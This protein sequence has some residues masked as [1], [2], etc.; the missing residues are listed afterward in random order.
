V[1]QVT[2]P[3]SPEQAATPAAPAFTAGPGEQGTACYFS[4]RAD[5][6]LTAGGDR[7]DSKALVAGHGRLPLG[8]RAR[9]TNL[10]NG[11]SVEVRIVDRF[12]GTSGRVINLSEQA[13]REIGML[14]AGTAQVRVEPVE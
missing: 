8:S 7:L 6:A 9:V 10:G 13:A 4:S 5:G 14:R 12:P 2:Q 3:V 1:A 11:K